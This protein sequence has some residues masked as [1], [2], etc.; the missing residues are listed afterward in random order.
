M[1]ESEVSSPLHFHK[2]LVCF[3]SLTEQDEELAAKLRQLEL[4]ELTAAEEQDK[5]LAEKLQ[6]QFSTEVSYVKS[7]K[8]I[9]TVFMYR[10]SFAVISGLVMYCCSAP[11]CPLVLLSSYA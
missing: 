3:G 2:L 11:A 4:Q 5:C 7:D 1:Y 10:V 8:L 9:L 6:R